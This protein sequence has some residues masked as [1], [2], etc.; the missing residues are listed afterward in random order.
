MGKFPGKLVLA[1]NN[2]RHFVRV[3]KATSSLHFTSTLEAQLG[4][5]PAEWEGKAEL[6]ISSGFR[7][8]CNVGCALCVVSVL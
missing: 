4:I 6:K 3:L 2:C 1:H 8:N 5:F 7:Q